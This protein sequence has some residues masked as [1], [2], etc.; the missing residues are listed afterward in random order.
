MNSLDFVIPE[1]INCGGA[2]K[3]MDIWDPGAKYNNFCLVA[4]GS[5][6]A[7]FVGSYLASQNLASG[8]TTLGC[9]TY[10]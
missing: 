6:I 4:P 10:G 3:F 1:F 7:G 9:I 2:T 8:M 5:Q